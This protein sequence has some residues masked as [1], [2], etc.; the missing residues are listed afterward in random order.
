VISGRDP[1]GQ[2]D[3]DGGVKALDADAA[4]DEDYGPDTVPFADLDSEP[5]QT[6][7]S[8]HQDAV[9]AL[10]ASVVVKAAP[11][12]VETQ[13]TDGVASEQAIAPT[14][15]PSPV[16]APA[17]TAPTQRVAPETSEMPPRHEALQVE[18]ALPVEPALPV[19]VDQP[20]LVHTPHPQPPPPPRVVLIPKDV[21]LPVKPENP[22][23]WLGAGERVELHGLTLQ[24]PCYFGVPDSEQG[25]IGPVIIDPSLPV[26]EVDQTSSDRAQPDHTQLRRGYNHFTPNERWRFIAWTGGKLPHA[27]LLPQF[28]ALR[29]AGLQ[30]HIIRL[31]ESNALSAVSRQLEDELVKLCRSASHDKA[32]EEVRCAAASLLNALRAKRDLPVSVQVHNG[33]RPLLGHHESEIHLWVARIWPKHRSFSSDWWAPLLDAEI[34]AMARQ[35]LFIANHIEAYKRIVKE[36]A[37]RLEWEWNQAPAPPG[38]YWWRQPMAVDGLIPD[39]LE[40]VIEGAANVRAVTREIGSLLMRVAWELPGLLEVAASKK[41]SVEVIEPLAAGYSEPSSDCA[42]HNAKPS[43]ALGDTSAQAALS[44]IEARLPAPAKPDALHTIEPKVAAPRPMFT[45]GPA[46]AVPQGKAATPTPGAK[47][48]AASPDRNRI[49]TLDVEADTGPVLM[50]KAWELASEFKLPNAPSIASKPVLQAQQVASTAPAPAPAPVSSDAVRPR[51]VDV[52]LTAA[53]AAV[54]RR[55]GTADPSTTTSTAV[56]RLDAARLER[57]REEDA[58]TTH[59]L[60]GVFADQEQ[61][62]V[63]VAAT[64]NPIAGKQL[65]QVTV[66]GLDP[67]AS[68]VFLLVAQGG[69]LHALRAL[70]AERAVMLNGILEL[71]NEVAIDHT[72]SPLLQGDDTEVDVDSHVLAELRL[73]AQL[74]P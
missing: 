24:G 15:Q 1:G 62:A 44:D 52:A 11:E 71:I 16:R 47:P 30:T 59:L 53:G 41:A 36:R 9:R 10:L 29:L 14:L 57:L 73:L 5:P 25:A 37:A 22:V 67:D 45:L 65:G 64:P 66:L 46:P 28:L 69:N 17:E 48:P 34:A 74:P 50:L 6:P 26:S 70:A 3:H 19:K 55:A 39:T 42:A 7:P 33:Q 56:F 12:A 21:E 23:R 4:H 27:G 20:P 13:T 49:S 18:L 68:S 38:P 54:A 51:P 8:V 60:A 43:Q 63:E 35:V 2:P 58:R 61:P 31:T 40:V 72:G 32:A